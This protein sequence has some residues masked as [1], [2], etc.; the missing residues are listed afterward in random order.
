MNKRKGYIV[1][2]GI[3]CY[4]AIVS[5]ASPQS[6]ANYDL[7]WNVIGGGGGGGTS[8]SY[9]MNSTVGQTAIGFSTHNYELGAGYWYGFISVVPEKPDLIIA[10]KWVNWP[11]CHDPWINCTIC[12]NVTNTGNG[13]APAGHNT[14]LYVDGVGVAH[15]HVPVNLAPGENY[16][17]CFDSYNWIYT[18]PSDNITVCADND[19]TI[20]ES[21]ETNNCAINTWM[22]GDVNDDGTVNVLDVLG[23][24]RRALDPNYPLTVPWAADVNGDGTINVLDV[25]GVYRRALDPNYQLK[26][27]WAGDVNGD[28]TINVL[29]VLGV[30]RKALDPGYDLGC[31]YG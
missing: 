16:T 12:Y 13:T 1:V 27:P 3:L 10:E 15:D 25:L 31:C 7:S 18:P 9:A 20:A 14:S 30:Y 19:N 28:G 4:L 5:T 11:E 26:V 21:N 29:D 8:N 17:G 24:Y 22:C 6:S 23:V 2:A